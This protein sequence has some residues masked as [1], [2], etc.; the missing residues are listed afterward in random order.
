MLEEKIQS[1]KEKE[2]FTKLVILQLLDV[3]ANPNFSGF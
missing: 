2:M 3:T 1:N